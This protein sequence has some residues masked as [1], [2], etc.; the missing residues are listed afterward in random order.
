[1]DTVR[2]QLFYE[3]GN[4][5][6]YL[7]PDVVADFSTIQLKS[8]GDHRVLVSGV[9]GFEP[10]PL[11]KVS[12]AYKDGYKAIGDIAIC[13]PNARA[14][15]EAFAKILWEKAGDQFEATE[16]EYFGW[17]AFHRSM[18]H[19]VDGNEITLRLGARSQDRDALRS[20][21]KLIPA[22]ILSGPPGVCVLGGVPRIQ[23][24]VSYWP[25]LMPKE[26]ISPMIAR[27][28][29]GFVDEKKIQETVIGHFEESRAEAQVA[30]AP[31]KS[32][33]E[34]VS[35]DGHLLSKI[36]LARSGDKGDTSNIGVMARSE[37][38]YQFLVEWLT[39]QRVKDMFQELCHG[40]VTRYELPNMS[41]L[42][43]L[44]ESSLGGGGTMTLRV[45][46]QGKSFAQAL[47]RQ[48]APIPNELLN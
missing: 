15:A 4:P 42:N 38:S 48:K 2:E 11:Y 37:A 18:G 6:A 25:A 7:T 17:N 43:F 31:Q 26:A 27:Y 3:M 47:L 46:A 23:D 8:D 13:G 29:N 19:Q 21:G 20:F 44:L 24:V 45:D 40:K 30:E 14:K 1:V 5:K 10:T 35:G 28:D 32:V 39:A 36:C 41:G 33:Q 9:K 34:S 12:M 22:L 16:T